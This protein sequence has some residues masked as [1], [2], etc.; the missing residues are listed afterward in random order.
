MAIEAELC[1]K[2]MHLQ[3][4]LASFEKSELQPQLFLRS[5]IRYIT[6]LSY[7]IIRNN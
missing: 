2:P 4:H 6:S 7:E 3:G 5:Q 1:R